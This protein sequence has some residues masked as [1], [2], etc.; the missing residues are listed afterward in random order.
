[1]ELPFCLPSLML[2][3]RIVPILYWS[4]GSESFLLRV[5][6]RFTNFFACFSSWHSFQV[7]QRLL[8]ACETPL[9]FILLLICFLSSIIF[10]F[11]LAAAHV[12][13]WL[14]FSVWGLV[15][16]SMLRDLELRAESGCRLHILR[17][18]LPMK[19]QANYKLLHF[20]SS[21]KLG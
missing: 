13:F 18:L 1:M 19:R 10:F 12:L 17:H 5:T 8:N 16:Y 9:F 15:K 14:H 7:N 20:F 3:S 11:F 2:F 4:L 6:H 21:V